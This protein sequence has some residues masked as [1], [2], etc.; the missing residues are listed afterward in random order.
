MYQ[1]AVPCPPTEEVQCSTATAASTYTSSSSAPSIAVTPRCGSIE[2]RALRL[3]V[4]LFGAS[5]SRP[6]GETKSSV[7]DTDNDSSINSSNKKNP[8]SPGTAT[9][10][11]VRN[12]TVVRRRDCILVTAP[13]GFGAIVF[14]FKCI[15]DCIE[16]SDHLV[17]LNVEYGVWPDNQ[18]KI[19]QKNKN[20]TVP[21]S[22]TVPYP[23]TKRVRIVDGDDDTPTGVR[24]DQRSKR[25]EMKKAKVLS[26]LVQL[27]HDED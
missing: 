21:C 3:R 6:C 13:K 19:D 1:E 12:A 10:G 5:S 25:D 9:T 17:K 23:P 4:H 27:L 22:D 18:T 8:T 16:F 11:M 2:V 7:K 24:K 20:D 14:K 15:S 26:H